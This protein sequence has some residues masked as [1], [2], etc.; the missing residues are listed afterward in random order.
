MEVLVA[1]VVLQLHEV[2]A[3]ERPGCLG[4][5]AL[6]GGGDGGGVVEVAGGGDADAEH[7]VVRGVPGEPL[8]VGADLGVRAGSVAEQD[9][10]GDEIGSRG[11][12]GGDGGL[13]AVGVRGARFGG[14]EGV[15]RTQLHARIVATRRA[16]RS[17][18]RVVRSTMVSEVD[19][20]DLLSFSARSLPCACGRGEDD[21]VRV[22]LRG[23]D[24]DNVQAERTILW[25]GGPS[26][27][28]ELIT[29]IRELAGLDAA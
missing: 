27:T 24:P 1:G 21:S 19:A 7:A 15:V 18:I 6:L 23:R 14:R 8:A 28:E 22:V 26:C 16:L 11:A 10:A 13:V 9:C 20:A 4:E 17:A 5:G 29:E 2:L 12:G 3:V 25:D